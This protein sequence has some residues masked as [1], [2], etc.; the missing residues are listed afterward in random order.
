MIANY[1]THTYRCHHATGTERKYIEIAVKN[2]I[3]YMG[4]SDHAPFAFPDGM[5]SS[6][7]IYMADRF[8]YVDF[9]SKLREEYRDKIDIKIG[10]EMEYFPLYFKDMLK[11][12]IESGAEYLILGQHAIN[13]MYDKEN[14]SSQCND[15]VEKLETYV[16]EVCEGMRTGVFSYVAHPDL[17]GF[18]GDRNIYLQK[19]RKICE[20][21]KECNIPLEINFLGIREGRIYPAPD[22]W[23]MVGE[24]GC[25]VVYGFDSHSNQSA[26]DGESLEIAEEMREKYGLHVLEIPRIIDI[27]K[28]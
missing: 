16:E 18:T 28:L 1:H 10:Y 26:Y 13:S 4:F 7:R 25:D 20:T 17:I 12:A 3:K 19:M 8:S 2:G 22:F 9:I 6:Y 21:S 11:I 24:V 15:S 14:L 27:R 5:E 23:E